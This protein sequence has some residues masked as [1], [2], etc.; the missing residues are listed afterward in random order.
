MREFFFFGDPIEQRIHRHLLQNKATVRSALV[1]QVWIPLTKVI[2]GSFVDWVIEIIGSNVESQFLKIVRIELCIPQDIW[3]CLPQDFK[4]L[5]NDLTIGSVRDTNITNIERYR[6]K[7]LVTIGF[8][9]PALKDRDRPKSNIVVQLVDSFRHDPI[10]FI[11]WSPLLE[12]TF[13]S[14]AQ[15]QPVK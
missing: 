2:I 3:R 10:N 4:S 6:T 11:P 15:E 1:H 12:H 13:D 5:G 8:Q 14:S 9:T 7:P